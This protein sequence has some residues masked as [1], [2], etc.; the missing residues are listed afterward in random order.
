MSLEFRLPSDVGTR[1]QVL[2]FGCDW[3]QMALTPDRLRRNYSLFPAPDQEYTEAAT[4]TI[5]LVDG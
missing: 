5:H 4:H 3:S 2:L 1:E